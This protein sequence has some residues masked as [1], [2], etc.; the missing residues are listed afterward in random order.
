MFNKLTKLTDKM[1][2]FVRKL[3]K[4]KG[5]DREEISFDNIEQWFNEKSGAYYNEFNRIRE[6]INNRINESIRIIKESIEKLKTAQLQNPNISIRE[7]QFMEGNREAYINRTRL[8]IE[9]KLPEKIEEID[10]FYSSFE[11]QV[12]SFKKSTMK[13]YQILQHFF[14]HETNKILYSVKKIEKLAKELKDLTENEKISRISNINKKISNIK[15]KKRLKE[16]LE[17]EISEKNNDEKNLK[18]EIKNDEK[19]ITELR[20]SREFVNYKNKADD[21]K[22]IKEKLKEKENDILNEFSVLEKAM[23]KYARIS[24]EDDALINKYIGNPVNALVN[25]NELR[26][27]IIFENLKKNIDEDK[28]ELK[29]KKKAKSLK[30]ID[31]LNKDFFENF[32]SDY[33]KLIETK[34]SLIKDINESNARKI[35]YELEDKIINDKENLASIKKQIEDMKQQIDKINIKEMKNELQDEI[36]S[37]SGEEIVII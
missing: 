11:A 26:I 1:L 35:F 14:A 36:K 22:K 24:F 16:E 20:K 21:L 4:K 2:D 12:N 10:D 5:A 18:E 13:P 33:N 15:T 29:D 7:K 6:G 27:I 28:I 37:V 31:N 23:K 9:I 8:F 25:D 34:N 3:F 17:K 19:N 30:T 32:L